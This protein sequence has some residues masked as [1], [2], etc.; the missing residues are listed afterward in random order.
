MSKTVYIEVKNGIGYITINR[1]EAL[2]A[3]SSQFWLWFWMKF[4]IKLRKAEEIQDCHHR[5]AGEIVAGA[6][7]KEM[8]LMSP[9]QAFEY[10]TFA[11]IIL[12]SRFTP[13]NDCSH[14][15][16]CTR[17]RYGITLSTNIRIGW[18]NSGWLPRSWQVLFQDLL[19]LNG[20]LLDW[21]SRAK[22]LSS[23][24]HYTV[25]VKTYDLGIL[26]SW[27]LLKNCCLQLKINRSHHEECTVSCW[28]SKTCH[29]SWCGTS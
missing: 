5:W 3:L 22:N 2:N 13:T 28:K 27:F 1:P 25:K 19:V 7:I 8:D 20:C 14:Q 6:D 18:E 12:A 11:N 10:M 29:S 23:L 21:T 24:L 16:L 4:L 26:N 15:W 9:I 17:W